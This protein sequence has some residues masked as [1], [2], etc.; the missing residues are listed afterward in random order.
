MFDGVSTNGASL[1]QVQLGDSGG[2]ETSG[3]AGT[4]QY[5]GTGAAA[6]NYTSGV[7]LQNNNPSASNLMVG[8]LRVENITGNTWSI[9]G[10]IAFSNTNF[11]GIVFYTKTLSG[12]LDR[13]RITTVNGTDT[14]DAGTINLLW[15]G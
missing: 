12:A 10:G 11:S 13:V 6:A 8:S 3:Y 5:F 9:T 7:V 14:F 1:L 15:E 4:S 2:I